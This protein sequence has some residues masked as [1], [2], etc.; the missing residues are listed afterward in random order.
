MVFSSSNHTPFELPEGKIEWE[1]GVPR[2]SVENAIKYADYAV[3]RFFALAR[4]SRYYANTVFV[5]VADHNVR[6]YGDDVVPVPGFHIPGLIH[7]AG[8]AAQRYDGLASQPDLLAT[9]LGMIGVEL[10]APVLGRSIFEPDRLP[11]VMM[12]FNDTY[13]FHRGDAVAV[14]RA[15]KPAS[16][17]QLQGGHLLPAVEDAGLERDGLA[18]LTVTEDLYDKRLYTAGTAR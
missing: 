3:G 9:A 2:K 4:Q 6:V 18:L 13:G 7:L 1:T 16:T 8:V 10:K 12:Q 14:L 15:D 11:F 5:V 17:W